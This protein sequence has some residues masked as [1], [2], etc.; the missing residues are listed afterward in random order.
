M[1]NKIKKDDWRIVTDPEN[2]DLMRM[3]LNGQEFDVQSFGLGKCI[4]GKCLMRLEVLI[5]INQLVIMEKAV[6]GSITKAT[7]AAL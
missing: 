3:Y 6:E 4:K 2:P 5:D 1:N 7:G